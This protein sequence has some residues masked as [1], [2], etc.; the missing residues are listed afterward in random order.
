MKEKLQ[1]LKKVAE[2]SVLVGVGAAATQ[3]HAV[4]TDFSTL[5][6]GID[7]STVTTGILAVAASLMTV[8]VAI[9]GAKILIGMVRGA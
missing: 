9:K 4:G 2:R 8:Y 5:T 7:F 1:Q 3:A 6:S